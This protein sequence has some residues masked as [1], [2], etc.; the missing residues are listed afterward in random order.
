MTDKKELNIKETF[1]LFKNK[2]TTPVELAKVCFEKITNLNHEL[3]AFVKVLNS[4]ALDAAEESQKRFEAGN[5]KGLLDGVPIAIKDNIAIEGIETAAASKILQGF[6]PP[7][8]ATVITK[9]KEAGAVILGKTNLD[10]FAM[11]SSTETSVFGPTKN[12]HDKTRVPGGSSGGSA[13]AVASGMSPLAIG[14]D[15]GGSIRQPASFCGIVGFKP[16]YGLVSR[17]GL[18]AMAS[19]LDQIGPMARSV[20]DV[21][22]LFEAISGYDPKDSTSLKEEIRNKKIEIRDLKIGIPNEYFAEGLD[23]KVKKVIEQAISKFKEMG[24][25]IK[26]VSLPN[27]KYALSCY[28]IIMPVEV[29]SNL[30]RYDGIKYGYSEIKNSELRIKNLLDVYLKSRSSGFGKEAKRRIMLGTYTSSAGYIDQYYNKA[31]KVRS[32]VKKDFDKVFQEVDFIL[33]PVA[34]TTAF[35]IGEKTTDPL[36][37]YLSDIYT[38]AVNL[39]GL[40]AIS[41]P[42][43]KVDDLPVG[44]QIIGPQF[45]DFKIFD[46]AKK[47]EGVKDGLQGA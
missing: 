41:V 16:T 4:N 25:E 20:E 46:L 36:T 6:V 12:P 2:K 22:I 13:V 11:G 28:Y 33:G 47:Y 45:S 9:L 24:A 29:A 32:L 35:K 31:Q 27:S 39:A 19:S 14:S 8:E 40:P 7:Y 21:E 5:P 18:F 3:N 43:K 44:L 34:P 17:Y 26:E 23:P 38:I 37:M 1:E 30:A 10:E 42:C 15:T